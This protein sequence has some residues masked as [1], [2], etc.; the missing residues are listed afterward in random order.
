M[1]K[2]VL[3]QK[4]KSHLAEVTKDNPPPG[5]YDEAYKIVEDK[6]SWATTVFPFTWSYVFVHP[7]SETIEITFDESHFDKI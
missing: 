3:N 4:G 6:A 5:G 1:S 2:Y 7:R